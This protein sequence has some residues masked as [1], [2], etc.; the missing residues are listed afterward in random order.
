MAEVVRMGIYFVIST[1]VMLLGLLKQG[2]RD[3]CG[4]NYE[5]YIKCLSE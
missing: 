5:A 1:D 2:V 4:K 3:E